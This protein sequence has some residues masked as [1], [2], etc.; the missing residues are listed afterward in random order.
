MILLG[1]L[2]VFFVVLLV[3]TLRFRPEAPEQTKTVPVELDEETVIA[4][5]QDMI[6]C[7][8][9]SCKDSAQ[10]DW[11]EFQ[12]F[13]NLLVERY[14]LVHRACTLEHIGATGLLY[15]LPGR[16]HD[17]P[18][19]CMAHYDVVPAQEDGWNK[20][21]FDAVLEDGV[22]W[23]RGTLDTK[24]TL[25][26]IFEALEL[27][28]QEGF[29][30]EQDLYLSFSGD[31]E[32]AGTSCPEIVQKLE[33]RG[34]RPAFVLDEG[35]AVVDHVF[36]GVDAP[37]AV[38]GTAEKGMLNLDLS[39]QSQGGHASTPSARQTLGDLSRA[40]LALE[41]QPFPYQLTK[42]TKE[43]FDTLGRHAGFGLRIV[44]A[45]LWCFGPVLN[46]IARKSGGELNAM[47]RTTVAMTCCSG[48][49]AYN[50]LPPQAK[51]GI[52]LRLTGEDTVERAKDTL[53]K[54]IA[55]DAIRIEEVYGMDPS[56]CSDTH[57][58]AW[59]TLKT[60]IHQ[61]WP[62]ALVS[63]YLMMA[64]S[65]SRHFSKITD[66]VYRF[67]AMHLSKEERSMIHSSDER[68]PVQTLLTTVRFYV[69]LIRR[70]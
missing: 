38:V 51:L 34:I 39:L 28:L 57:C 29:V 45:N 21:P 58:P 44:F 32:I 70:L 26:G 9:I 3:R 66:R 41:K 35:G 1:L 55:N 69:R 27:L 47:V 15:H 24:G 10:T 6:R 23:G 43:M 25:C 65:D 36:P 16:N 4:N 54:A 5:F 31:E 14:P 48:S 12:R 40:A 8:T 2:A 7:K 67:S 18:S 52:N 19:V 50:V 22:I 61:T 60:A 30:P 59:D 63:P 42:P 68:I 13:Q 62:E 46:W 37:C 56:P 33:Q 11:K 53:K 49:D 64:C 20:P 17:Q